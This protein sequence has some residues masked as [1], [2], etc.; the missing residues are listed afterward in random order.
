LWE[1]RGFPNGKVEGS[2]N[3]R[4][5]VRRRDGVRYDRL[6]VVHKIAGRGVDGRILSKRVI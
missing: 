5:S 6:G 4:V 3:R 1:G 2:E